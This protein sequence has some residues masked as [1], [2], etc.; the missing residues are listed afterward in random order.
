MSTTWYAQTHNTDYYGWRLVREVDEYNDEAPPNS[1]TKVLFVS[2]DPLVVLVGHYY[3]VEGETFYATIQGTPTRL[4]QPKTFIPFWNSF[5]TA[6][7]RN[8]GY[9]TEGTIPAGVT[10]SEDNRIDL[11]WFIKFTENGDEIPLQSTKV[12]SVVDSMETVGIIGVGRA[13]VILER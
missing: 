3:D 2:V 9:L 12:Q 6:E 7:R 1:N 8:I 11:L 4:Q 10:I 13:D 5:T